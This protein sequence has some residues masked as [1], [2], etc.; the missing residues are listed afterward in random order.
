MSYQYSEIYERFKLIDDFDIK[1]ASLEI[2]KILRDINQYNV[3]GDPRTVVNEHEMYG[4]LFA[5][6]FL[7]KDANDPNHMLLKK[8]ND[9]EI[10]DLYILLESEKLSLYTIY[11]LWIYVFFEPEDILPIIK[12]H[13]DDYIVDLLMKLFH[14]LEDL[15]NN[16]ISDINYER[17]EKKKRIQE[18]A[19]KMKER[20]KKIE[21][22]QANIAK[23]E[24]E[25]QANRKNNKF[26]QN[27]KEFFLLEDL[28]DIP[29]ED[30][31]Y[32]KLN[33][34][35]FC[36]D[37][38]SFKQMIKM[39]KDQKVKGNCKEAVDGQPLDCE[40]F[41][42]ISIG[43]NVYITEENYNNIKKNHM[44]NRQFSLKNKRIIDFTTG[45]HIM[46]E[47]SGKDTVYDLVPDK[48]NL[49]KGGKK[50]KKVKKKLKKIKKKTK[51]VK[52]NKK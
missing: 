18:E 23:R 42:P 6:L 2:F 30:L 21:K 15:L 41:Y 3:F 11:V 33:K 38:D 36:Y 37:K 17:Y 20:A 22:N 44:E 35:I 27:D 49:Q 48:Y 45:L 1:L 16:L 4:G 47:K 43:P 12:N 29:T 34:T 50:L 28:E 14:Y 5:E 9:T 7:L 8:F 40:W 13:Y 25:K 39:S 51:K 19:K 32:I 24:Q 31:S 52:K 26:C 46:S 10:D